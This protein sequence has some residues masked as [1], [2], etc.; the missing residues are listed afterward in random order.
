MLISENSDFDAP[1]ALA[2][3]E[4]LFDIEFPFAVKRFQKVLITGLLDTILAFEDPEMALS[5]G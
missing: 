4:I 5:S 3:K 1:R 2:S